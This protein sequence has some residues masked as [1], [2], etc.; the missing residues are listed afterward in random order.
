MNQEQNPIVYRASPLYDYPIP[1]DLNIGQ[2][3]QTAYKEVS[4]RADSQLEHRLHDP[5]L[6]KDLE[7]IEAYYTELRA[8]NEKRAKRKG[9]SQRE[10]CG[11]KGEIN[12]N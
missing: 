9:I 1:A 10:A 6:K 11:N 8:K 4:V 12:F 3:F 5:Q 2:A 7:R